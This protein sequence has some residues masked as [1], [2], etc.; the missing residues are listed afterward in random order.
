MANKVIEG[1]GF[2]A[3]MLGGGVETN[4]GVVQLYYDY[5]LDIYQE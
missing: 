2:V 5:S 1:L 4:V 3:T